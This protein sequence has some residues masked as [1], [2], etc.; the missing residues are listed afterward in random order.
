MIASS[1]GHILTEVDKLHGVPWIAHGGVG[2]DD[3]QVPRHAVG[4]VGLPRHFPYEG[5]TYMTSAHGGG[6]CC[7]IAKF[8]P[9]LSLVCAPGWRAWGAIQGKEGIK[10][11]SIAE[12]C[13]AIV[14][15]PEAHTI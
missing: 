5:I 6:Q 7:Q 9:F 14:Q 12:R 8:D 15:K 10:F 11:C 4:V 3:G 13:G 2:L 1:V